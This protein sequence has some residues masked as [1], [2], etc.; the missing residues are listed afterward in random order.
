MHW[1][2][3]KGRIVQAKLL[4]RSDFGFIKNSQT[5][6]NHITTY[7]KNQ[8]HLITLTPHN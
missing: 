2:L 1:L 5:L 8:D 4:L 3:I 6:K 7:C